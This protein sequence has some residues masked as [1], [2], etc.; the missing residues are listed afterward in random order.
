ML[1]EGMGDGLQSSPTFELIDVDDSKYLC[2]LSTILV[3]NIQELKDRISQIEFIFCNQLF[4]SFKSRSK[5]LQKQLLE[6]KEA[7]NNEWKKKESSLLLQIHELRLEKHSAQAEVERLNVSVEDTKTRLVNTEKLVS[8]Y[9]CEKA[10]L[11]ARVESLE[12]NEEIIAN[13]KEQLGQKFDEL[14]EAKRLQAK[15]LQQIDIKDQSLL[16]EQSKRKVLF[17]EFTKFKD[18]YKH[19]KSQYNF[20]LSKIGD[21]KEHKPHPEKDIPSPFLSKRSPKDSPNEETSPPTARPVETKVENDI[22]QNKI[23]SNQNVGS[24]K[25]THDKSLISP[26]SASTS[27]ASKHISAYRKSESS[28]GQ[29]R[30]ASSWRETRMRQ[31]PGGAD[32]H[33]DFLDTPMDI[34]RNLHMDPQE[35]VHDL[36][37]LAPND[38]DFNN[39]DDETQ[40]VNNPDNI[41]QKQNI[42]V[43]GPAANK[44]FK[45]IEPVRKKAERENLAGVECN[46]CKKF[47]D[48]V[49]PD[50]D[51]TN[52]HKTM[53][54]EHHD[55]VSRHRYRYAPPMTPEGFWNIGFESDL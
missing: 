17:E 50:N 47:Y 32:P 4:P 9:E 5:T 51:T 20:L 1:V 7:A 8:K 26:S 25:P 23:A 42:S 10:Q 18:N 28:I 48:A 14:V 24:V 34:V 35:E 2:G 45:Y 41:P 22:L 27:L 21:S 19:L 55:G 37:V 36:P 16:T 13:L 53:R 40:E 30:S 33:D 38:M 11:L 46:Q 12:R 52:G 31:E 43:L 44:G 15:L 54:C 29:K 6:A 3:A 39:S 49:L